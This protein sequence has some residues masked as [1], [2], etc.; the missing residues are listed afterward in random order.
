M[1]RAT[2]AVSP[3]FS[4]LLLWLVVLAC[5][6]EQPASG[7]GLSQPAS[8]PS[9][10][11]GRFVDRVYRDAD[12]DHKYVVFEPVGYTPDKAWPVIF[13]LHGA[14]GRGRDGRSA[15]VVG[16]GPA[17]KARM[18]TLPFLVV[19]PQNENLRSRLLGGWHEEPAELDR[20]LKILA[21]AE[22]HYSMDPARRVL[23]GV[24]MGGFG[25]WSL[26]ASNPKF[27]SAV[28]PVS[29]GGRPEFIP[30]LAQVPV[31]AFHAADDTLVPPSESTSL[32]EGIN[33]AG[34][35]G[36]VSILPRGGHNIG[37]AVFAQDA[38]F[39][40]L[41]NPQSTPQTDLD[42]SKPP[43]VPSLHDEL[44]FVTGADVSR[45]ARLHVG[46]DLLESLSR[47][48]PE[49][50]PANSLAGWKPGMQQTATA[51]PLSFSVNLMGIAYNG[52]LAGAQLTPMD[53]NLLRV[54]LALSNLTMTIQQT[55]LQGRLLNATAGP[56]QVV[57]GH[58]SPVWLTADIRP[59][60][61]N[62]RLKLELVSNQFQIPPGNWYI[63]RPGQ[64]QVRP[65][66]FLDD[67]V[68]DR[69]T[70]GLSERQ[71]QI[72][73]EVLNS[74]P[75]MLQQLEERVAG[76][77]DRVITYAKWPMPL[78]QPRFK[79]YPEA[80]T[81]DATGITLDVG[82]LVAA[83]APRSDVLPI[84]PYPATE[85]LVPAGRA[86]G[87]S[88]A[89][90]AR[91]VTAWSALLAASDVG[92]FHVLDM[93][94][95]SFQELG[96][97][98]FWASVLPESAVPPAGLETA[99]EFVLRQ[100][101]SIQELPASQA[102]ESPS[103]TSNG[104]FAIGIPQLELL[105]SVREP[106]QR[107]WHDWAACD[108]GFT[109]NFRLQLEHTGF[110]GRTLTF[111][112]AGV[113]TPTVTARLSTDAGTVQTD[114]IA[115]QF[116]QGWQDSF[117]RAEG[118]TVALP[119]LKLDELPLRWETVQF[120]AG[121]L[122]ASLSRPPVRIVNQGQEPVQYWVRE[123]GSAW[124]QPLTIEPGQSQDFRTASPLVWW[125]PATA[126]APET[127]F[128]LPLGAQVSVQGPHLLQLAAEPAVEASSPR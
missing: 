99:T 13:Y 42:W 61:E 32:I 29:G 20:A 124:S 15:L 47:I 1:R 28:V 52:Q 24:S 55:R 103:I 116:Q 96:R 59:R 97:D 79:L 66:P 128:T 120:T 38:V 104:G 70:E 73:Q 108:I 8:G 27:W 45:A 30:S 16:L 98:E 49:R 110:A 107:T 127:L 5:W 63:T 105:L 62:R 43:Q 117:A 89:V 71:R 60:V 18:T 80:V 78:W 83:L 6:A 102:G 14:S 34:G 58:R 100:P 68:A 17:V 46:T 54:Q 126:T 36:Y 118:R 94:A 90:S 106:G 112:P 35:R 7:A 121:H 76:F 122:L 111:G 113:A 101:L 114:R 44:L 41:E 119:D 123:R 51:G 91:L 22:Q 93:N 33:A 53:G 64:V 72:E 74:V 92:R 125:T 67:L 88:L 95:K 9:G 26:G 48:L 39:Q 65:L 81:V 11:T 85:E 109:Q 75:R 115:A 4:G 56:M 25:A 57:I 19:F 40:W 50:V 31:W 84:T 10:P 77:T 82:A 23:A 12:G 37:A 86:E 2:D 87:L 3:L 21:D 69:L